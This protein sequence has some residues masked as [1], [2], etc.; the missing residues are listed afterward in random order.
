MGQIQKGAPVLRF[1]TDELPQEKRIAF[2]T[3]VVGR[4]LIKVEFDEIPEAPFSQ[5]AVLQNLPGL[6]MIT[7]VGGGYR[8]RRTREFTVKGNDDF[9][10]KIHL[11]GSGQ[12]SQF[13]RDVTIGSGEAVLLSGKDVFSALI[14]VPVRYIAIGVPRHA[15]WSRVY[16]PEAVFLKP[17]PITNETLRLLIRYLS[18]LNSEDVLSATIEPRLGQMLVTHV[19]DLLALL[20]GATQDA[21]EQAIGNQRV[22]RLHAIKSDILARLDQGS[23]SVAMMAE[24][25]GVSTRY[26]QKLFELEGTTFSEFVLTERLARAHRMLVDPQFADRPISSIGYEAGFTDLS[27]FNRAFRRRYGATPSDVRNSAMSLATRS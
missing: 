16:N 15:L 21:A 10:L 13:G 26:V 18:L 3:E 14:P 4:Q 19:H 24:R 25:H 12:F 6:S 23:L 2:W 7:G 8:V 22:V 27:H 5:T 20:L 1:S 11:E 17:I 9:I